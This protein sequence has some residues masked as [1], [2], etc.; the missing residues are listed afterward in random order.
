MEALERIAEVRKTLDQAVVAA[1]ASVG[2]DGASL[3][4]VC[5]VLLALRDL[6]RDVAALDAEVEQAIIGMM[7]ES[8]IVLPSGQQ[9]EKRTGADRKAWDHKSLASVVADDHLTDRTCN[10]AG[11]SIE[12]LS[13]RRLGV[14]RHDENADF[15]AA[16]RLV[17][18]AS[19]P[20]GAFS[21]RAAAGHQ[22]LHRV[23]QFGCHP[24]LVLSATGHLG[25]R[26]DP[27]HC[28]NRPIHVAL[29][30]PGY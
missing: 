20:T 16:K 25:Q 2:E 30:R 5:E 27:H 15:A 26:P 23:D 17:H 14:V 28:L 4:D 3:D 6:K 8:I 12:C 22:H 13:Q 19:L 1:L 21:R 18:P 7:D 24:D 9:V 10:I 29:V 11:N